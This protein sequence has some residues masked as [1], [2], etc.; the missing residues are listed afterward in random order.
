MFISNFR[1]WIRST[2]S[3]S[4]CQRRPIGRGLLAERGA[5]L[6]AIWSGPTGDGGWRDEAVAAPGDVYDEPVAI[7]P[8]SQRATQGGHMDRKVGRRD[9]YVGPNPSH[10]FLLADQLTWTFK[11]DRED[12]QSTTS[13][14]HWLVPFQQKK[15]CREQAK[16]SE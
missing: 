12:F 15:L 5:V 13:K 4:H 7:A 10:Q 2:A 1:R 3:A 6:V 8:I 14:G 11:Q 9:K 16:R